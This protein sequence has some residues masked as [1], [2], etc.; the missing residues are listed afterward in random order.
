ME[1]IGPIR[2]ELLSGIRGE[3]EYDQLSAHMRA[4]HD[5]ALTTQ[6]FELAARLSNRC[7]AAGVSGS[8]VDF[9]ICAV[10]LDRG[11]SIFT[12]DADFERYASVV[13]IRLHRPR[14]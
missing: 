1:L 14:K 8:V 3:P 12:A 13:S 9:L 11:W 6:D 4:F 2:Q 5:D 10:A 7:R